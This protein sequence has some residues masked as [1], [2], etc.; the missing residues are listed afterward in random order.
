ML[1]GISGGLGLSEENPTISLTGTK[2][3][4]EIILYEITVSEVK[5]KDIFLTAYC[6]VQI[7]VMVALHLKIS[8]I[9]LCRLPLTQEPT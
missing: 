3:L 5:T 8:E 6:H 9:K 4:N 2:K 1:K 7:Q